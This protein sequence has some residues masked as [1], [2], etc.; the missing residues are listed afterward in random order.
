L[1]AINAISD[2]II[3]VFDKIEEEIK[4]LKLTKE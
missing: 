3:F 4:S 2:S 1:D